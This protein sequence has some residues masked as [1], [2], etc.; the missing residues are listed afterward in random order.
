MNLSR[1]RVAWRLTRL[2][3]LFEALGVAKHVVPI[4]SLAR[5]V[6]REP[7]GPRDPGRE[8]DLVSRALQ[9]GRVAGSPDR[10]CLQR[11]LLLFRVRS[12][13]GADPRLR[14]GFASDQGRLAGHAWVVVDDC[15]VAETAEGLARF[16][17]AFEFGRGGAIVTAP[18]AAHGH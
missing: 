18:E 9:A 8:Y 10:D 12:A 2:A 3:L 7:R 17:P 16:R 13:A 14:V 5:W 1:L 4:A 11:S 15:P 6:W